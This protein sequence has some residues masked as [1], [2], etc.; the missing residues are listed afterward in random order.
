MAL[1]HFGGTVVGGGSGQQLPSPLH[2]A[3][4]PASRRL[5][6]FLEWVRS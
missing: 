3:Q 2:P 5:L 6:E 1:G 4:L